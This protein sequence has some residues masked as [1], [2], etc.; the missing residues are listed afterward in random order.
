MPRRQA[1]RAQHQESTLERWAPAEPTVVFDTYWRFAVERQAVFFRRISGSPPPWTEDPILQK[2]KFTN[3]YRASDRVSQYLVRN[4]LYE[5]DESPEEVFFRCILFKLFNRVATWELLQDR[6]GAIA[7]ASFSF[8]RYSRVLDGA[9]R[10]G[11]RIYSA[12]YIMPS[13]RRVF[14]R[15]R[16][17]RNHL[18]LLERMM[19]DGVPGRIARAAK[20][21]D[22]FELLR[23]YPMIGDFLAYQYATDINYSSLTDF[24][25]MEFV[26]AG[27]GAR[28]GIRKC[29]RSLGG[30]TEEEIIRLVT[31]RQAGEFA[32]RGLEFQT[33]WGRPLQLVDC[34]NLFCEV[35]KYARL[36][37]PEVKGRT[38]RTRIK[39][40]HRPDRTPIPYW[41]PPK[42]GINDRVTGALRQG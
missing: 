34:Q 1:G 12:A 30:L 27:P 23:S 36:A 5:G 18:L 41:Y 17:H 24:S 25:E 9:M 21:K 15:A 39:Q 4:V 13:G 31:E 16:K 26:V 33:L 6:V 28:D 3:A 14:G 42:W 29:F 40:V 20:M 8:D 2:H 7:Y 19:R 10:K 37:H 38:G 11:T 35:D 32:S 22:V